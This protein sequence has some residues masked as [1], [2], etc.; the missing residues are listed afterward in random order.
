MIDVRQREG[1]EQ[2]GEALF[3]ARLRLREIDPPDA[4]DGEVP[5]AVAP[6]LI[7]EAPILN[8]FHDASVIGRQRRADQTPL[9]PR[10][11]D[12]ESN[13]RSPARIDERAQS[14]VADG[15]ELPFGTDEQL[16][17]SIA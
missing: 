11:I 6:R 9:A 7:G 4:V 12:V 8:V 10:C 17:V 1:L 2:L 16:S 13:H 14:I 5:E 15:G 3:I